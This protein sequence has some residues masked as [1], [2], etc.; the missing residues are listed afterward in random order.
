MAA[1]GSRPR[2]PSARRIGVAVILSPRGP[3]QG[4]GAGRAP[5]PLGDPD[6]R[7]DAADRW[8][9]F[10]TGWLLFARLSVRERRGRGVGFEPH[11]DHGDHHAIHSTTADEPGASLVLSR[12]RTDVSG[13]ASHAITPRVYLFGNVGRT[14]SRQ[15]ANA[16][17]ITV[18][19]GASVSF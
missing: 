10:G 11:V 6:E 17:T 3:E 18:S 14:L 2:E 4:P 9:A 1:S 16:A 7:G 15:D 12:T 13:G 5:F 19:G 8:R